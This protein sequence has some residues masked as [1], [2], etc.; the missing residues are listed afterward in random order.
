MA[1][2]FIDIKRFEP[3]FMERWLER[4]GEISL[5]ASFIGGE[6]VARMEKRLADYAETEF[7][8]SC[9]NGTDAL[10]LALR[11]IGVGPGDTVLLPD[12]TFWA[13][14]EAVVNVA[15][16]PVTVDVR[17]EDQSIDPGLL[18][19]AL[20]KHKPAAVMLVNLY[21]WGSSDLE[22]IRATVA[23]AGIPLI[24]D[25]AQ[26]FGVRYRDRSIFSGAKIATTSFYPAKVLGAAGDGGAVF[27]SDEIIADK[28]RRL[29][30][31]G[32]A[33]HYG[34]DMIGWNSR[35]DSMQAAYVDLSLDYL[36]QRI[37]SRRESA[38]AYREQLKGLEGF[39]VV[40]APE[41][42]FENG[43]CNVCFVDS[44]QRKTKLEK[45][46]KEKQIGYATIYPC[47][48]S[49]QEGARGFLHD[50]VKPTGKETGA[51]WV[52]DHAISLPLFPYIREE[53]RNEV[54][55]TVRSDLAD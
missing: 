42:Y 14:F 10:Q 38:A 20:E 33:S 23:A 53:E 5:G 49:E 15:A 47:P 3:G 28:V 45:A 29:A 46:L 26:A 13:T 21:G 40:E 6:T 55:K 34:H 30:N 12:A 32:R 9:A 7:A 4:V 31:H 1:V 36:D 48:V 51:R 35:M 16:R 2:P 27:C 54:I 8:V 18:Q 39:E 19:G 17:R 37:A 43:Y 25:S 41:G 11:A 24:E 22:G 52:S 50:R 44:P